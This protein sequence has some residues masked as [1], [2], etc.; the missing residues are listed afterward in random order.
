MISLSDDDDD[1][2]DDDGDRLFHP[3]PDTIMITATALQP[4]MA[5]HRTVVCHKYI[6][7]YICTNYTHMKIK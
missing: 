5:W 6:Y 4:G 3:P 1:D 2:D 7:I